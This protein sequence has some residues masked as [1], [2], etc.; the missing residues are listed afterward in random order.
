MHPADLF[1]AYWTLHVE[2]GWGPEEIAAR[3]GGTPQF[4]RRLFRLAH[5]SP[6]LIQL[7]RDGG[8]KMEHLQAFAITDDHAR[9]EQ[10]YE[11]L[12]YNRDPSIIRRELTQG[13]VPATERRA[14][15][16]GAEAYTEAGGSI[17]RDLFTEDRGGFFEDPALLDRL[18]AE[19]LE[20]IG[21]PMK[22]PRR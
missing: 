20:R 12:S 1:E 15:F 2:R 11:L 19:K 5:V 8:L 13:H 9:Q 14:V 18:A 7:Y 16:V 22:P 17:I 10:V 21:S 3:G 6:R 4:V